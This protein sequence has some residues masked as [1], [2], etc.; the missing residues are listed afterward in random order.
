MKNSSSHSFSL[1]GISAPLWMTAHIVSSIETNG[2][3]MAL[4]CSKLEDWAGLEAYFIHSFYWRFITEATGKKK[5]KAFIFFVEK[6]G[7]IGT[8]EQAERR[9]LYY[10]ALQEVFIDKHLEVFPIAADGEYSM[11][12]R[13]TNTRAARH[14]LLMLYGAWKQW[15][16]NNMKRPCR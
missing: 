2:E 14:W 16:E 8:G 4:H 6:M 11:T 10:K 1:Q 7:L 12:H 3:E 5:K 9:I 13:L 15:Q